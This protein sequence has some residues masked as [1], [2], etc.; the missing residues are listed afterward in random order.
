MGNVLAYAIDRVER[1]KDSPIITIAITSPGQNEDKTL[2]N[3]VVLA[4][5]ALIFFAPPSGAG[6]AL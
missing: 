6:L 2:R 4:G 5:F 1:S 3:C